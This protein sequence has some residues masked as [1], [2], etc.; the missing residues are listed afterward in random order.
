MTMEQ[1]LESL[2]SN[3][4]FMYIGIAIIV[5][6]VIYGVVRYVRYRGL[7][8]IRNDVY[9][10]F[11]VAENEF[12]YGANSEKFDYVIGRA[13]DL[14]PPVMKL[15]ISESLLRKVVQIWFESVKDLLDDGR[16]NK[17]I[18]ETDNQEVI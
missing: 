14:L 16:L 6:L 15:F 2:K 8:G 18:K 3:Q 11:C 10:L 7:E 4:V 17:S 5:A 13:Y 9:K 1:I 12:I